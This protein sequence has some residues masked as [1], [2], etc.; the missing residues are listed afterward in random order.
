MT[1]QLFQFY[2]AKYLAITPIFCYLNFAFFLHALAGIDTDVLNFI[3][4][5]T[6]RWK[7]LYLR[8]NDLIIL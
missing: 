6:H 7:N 2:H 8:T 1:I 3:L 4:G 5:Q